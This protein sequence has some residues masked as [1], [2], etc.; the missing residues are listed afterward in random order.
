MSSRDRA[1]RHMVGAALS[2]RV[3]YDVFFSR[4]WSVGALAQLAAYRYSSS[5]ANVPSTSYCLLPTLALALTFDWA[6]RGAP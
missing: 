1:R 3:G 6:R 5:E 2:V 4:R